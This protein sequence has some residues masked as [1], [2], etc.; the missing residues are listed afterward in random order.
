MT[1]AEEDAATE[2]L[3]KL[4]KA[5]IPGYAASDPTMARWLYMN[6]HLDLLKPDDLEW[7]RSVTDPEDR[8]ENDLEGCEG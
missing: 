1:A 3:T 5:I 7:A 4:G 6:G 2:S 8:P